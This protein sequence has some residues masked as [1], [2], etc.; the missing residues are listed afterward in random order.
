MFFHKSAPLPQTQGPRLLRQQPGALHEEGYRSPP[1]GERP[2]ASLPP[3]TPPQTTTQ[4]TCALPTVQV[5]LELRHTLTD[6]TLIEPGVLLPSSLVT[7]RRLHK[8]P[9]SLPPHAMPLPPATTTG[10]H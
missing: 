7:A 5:M 6:L 3:R 9:R 2:A 10:G 4:A 8:R 1:N